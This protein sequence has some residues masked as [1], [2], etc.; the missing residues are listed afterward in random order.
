MGTGLKRKATVYAPIGKTIDELSYFR[1][2][3]P[4]L[5]SEYINKGG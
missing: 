3:Y 1:V 5:I 4:Q 2:W